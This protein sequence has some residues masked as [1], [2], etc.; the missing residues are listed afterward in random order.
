MADEDP[1]V[2]VTE[3][4]PTSYSDPMNDPSTESTEEISEQENSEEE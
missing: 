3:I 1:D 4:D 2:D